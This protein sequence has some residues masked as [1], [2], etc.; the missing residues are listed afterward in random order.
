METALKGVPVM[1]PSAPEGVVNAGGEWFYEEYVRGA[2]V[3]SIG[4]QDQNPATPRPSQDMPPADER[5]R[6]I[7]LFRN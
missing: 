4:M 1:E 5:K 3:S 2:G 7:D 6:I